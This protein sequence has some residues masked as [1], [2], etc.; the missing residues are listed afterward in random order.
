M[1][2]LRFLKIISTAEAPEILT[3]TDGE[4]LTYQTKL[5]GL[6]EQTATRLGI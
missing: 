6:R 4:S 2:D 1:T 3:P 5:L